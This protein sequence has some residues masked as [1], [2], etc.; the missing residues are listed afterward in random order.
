[1]NISELLTDSRKLTYILGG[2]IALMV[3]ITFIVILRNFGGGT[4]GGAAVTLEVWGVYD[5]PSTFNAAITAFQQANKDI[6]VHYQVIPFANYENQVVNALAAGQGPDVWMVQNTWL[7]KHKNQLTPVP[8]A[9]VPGTN[10]PVMTIKQFQDSFVDVAYND[11]VSGGSI[12]AMPLYVDT[13]ALYYNKDLFG[14]AG[15][16]LPP[17]TWND[18]LDDVKKLTAYDTSRNI[19]RSGAAMGTADNINRSMDI[20]EMLMLQSGVQMTNTDNTQAT[21]ALSVDGQPV[22]ERALQ[23]YTDFANPAK[24]VYTWNSTMDYNIDAFAAGKTA[25]MLNY[26]YQL[27]TIRQK[28][29]RL[30]LGIASAPQI[31]AT[32]ARNFASY[33]GLAVSLRSAYPLE[34]WEFVQYMT[35]GAGAVPYLNAAARPT[36]LKALVDQQK[37]DPDLGVFAAQAL[38]ARS[39]YQADP[40]AIDAVFADMI[41]AVNRGQQS[42]SNALR[43]AESKVSV[44]M[45]S[46][47]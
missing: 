23:F 41:N 3:F 16:A 1:M 26:A 8:T 12:Y 9:N 11:F 5:D 25:M 2:A 21:F 42:V 43:S 34:A 24:E 13:L 27:P 15:I 10:A 17:K 38:T 44:I 7:P 6:T 20:L 37:N 36:G 29:P 14:S 4:G 22:G 30:N 35:A 45:S 46:V 31:N 18:F 40:Q 32:D 33:W 19:T 47:H 28:A 39:W